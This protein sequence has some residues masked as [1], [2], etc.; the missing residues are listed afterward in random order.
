M[1][2][3]NRQREFSVVGYGE[4]MLR[5]SPSGKERISQGET[6]EKRA[7]GS[8]LNV[9]S[10]IS[11]LGLRTGLITKLPDNEIGKF[12][13]NQVRFCG[14][15][16]DCIVYDTSG[17][18]RLGVYYYEGGVYPRRPT[19]VYDRKAS[20]IN[21]LSVEEID[22]AI[23]EKAQLFHI[24]GISLALSAACRATALEVI[25]RFKEKGTRISFDVNYR[26]SLWSEEEAR[27][28]IEALLPSV[29]ILFVSEESS[30]RMFRKTGDLEDIMKSYA[31]DYGVAI[32]A[33]TERKVTRPT[34]HTFGSTLYDA[35]EDRFYREEPYRDIEVVDRVGSGDAY[36]AGALYGLLQYQDCQRAVEFG[37]AMSAV[38]NT[39]P[40]DLPAS[41][42]EEI[43]MIIAAHQSKGPQSEMKR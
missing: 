39:I 24:S 42:A 14:V 19:V 17:D 31:R 40:G 22:P 43:E 12:V 32:V 2:T 11:M 5:L 23:Y 18:A 6:F 34:R 16:D 25:R 8:E 35:Q 9:V 21:T 20:S 13:K 30:R 33:P 4:V 1:I 28:T 15:S 38:K 36:L 26:A 37:N 10:G 7:G 27:K 41:D 3:I 29:D